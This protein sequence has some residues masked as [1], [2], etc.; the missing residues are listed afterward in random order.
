[1]CGIVGYVGKREAA[2]LL[3]EALRRLEY[4][5][6]DSAGMCTLFE[7]KLLVKKDKGKVEEIEERLRLSELPGS[8]GI[9]HT[10]WAT[11]GEPSQRNAHPHLDSRGIVAVVHNGI[12]E[13][14][15]ELRKFLEK[16][17]YTFASDTDSEVVPNLISYYL[18][19]GKAFSDA[20]RETCK[21]LEGSFALAILCAHEP[22]TVIGV[23]KES[24][25]VIGIG[26]GEMFLSSDIPAILKFTRRIIPLQDWEMVE[27]RPQKPRITLLKTKGVVKRKPIVIKWTLQ[28]AEKMG[29]PHFMIKEIFEQPSAVRETLRADPL[30]LKK[31]CEEMERADKIYLVGCGSSFHASLVGKYFLSKL[32]GLSV[33]AILSSEFPE[34]C[35]V[36][37]GE[38][39]LAITQSG[40]TA[41]T[42]KAVRFA[43]ER[44]AR[45]ACLVN[46]I[47]STITRESDL[48]CCIHAGP[49]ISVVAT[50]TF[51]SQL[52]YLLRI[53]L[54]LSSRKLNLTSLPTLM[55]TVLKEAEPKTKTLASTYRSM[56]DVYLISR[57]I[58]YPIA[59]EGALKLK[60]VAYIHAEAMAGGELK[61]GT[62]ALIQQG[63]PVIAL[64]P[65]GEV[66][67]KMFSNIQEV[68]ARGARVMSVASKEIPD[69]E[70]LLLPNVDEI[71][72]PF[73]SV[74]PLQ[75]LAYY[76]SV[77]RGCDPDRPRH[78]AKSVTVE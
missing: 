53:A 41:D 56:E 69:T 9:A 39:V 62:L 36:G 22:E 44:K 45:T 47:G 3:L 19:E 77:E 63:T 1:M 28:M 21:R 12:I 8:I 60:E 15:L 13:N 6:Y 48:T 49:E 34:S 25:L 43:R 32:A 52:A 17:G 16:K 58:G 65:A 54:S 66:E 29:Y 2:P 46:V 11:H 27:L 31:L 20:V 40:E 67:D 68:R 78:L 72:F 75:L 26:R 50:K 76:L 55:E 5:G 61:H 33:E 37:K 51:T 23:R 74:L 18:H 42:L 73:L 35:G 64:V 57:G 4:R 71:F 7:G 70:T 59:M 24:P 14:Y 38:L 30:A 10:R